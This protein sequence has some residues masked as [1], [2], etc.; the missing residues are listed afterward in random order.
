MPPSPDVTAG[1]GIMKLISGL[2]AV[3]VAASTLVAA[4]AGAATPSQLAKDWAASELTG[5]LVIGQYGSADVG[6]TID[7]GFAFDAMGRTAEAQLVGDAID[8]EL[9]P[10]ANSYGYVQGEEYSYPANEYL[11]TGRYANATAKAA[12]FTQRIDRDP[13]TQYDVNLVAQL[14]DLTDDTT[15]VIADE[16]NFDNY[17]NTIGQAFAAEALT[18]AGS[19]EAGP[20]T[21][22]LLAQQCPAGYFRFGL[23]A[24]PCA[25]DATDVAPDTTGLAVLSLL[26]SGNTSPDVTS[27]IAEATAWLESV[28]L[29][30]GSLAGDTAAPGSNSN[31][32]GLAGWALGEAGRQASAARA[33]AWTRSMQVADAGACSSQAPTGA[34]AYNPADLAAGRTSGITSNATVRDKWRRAT[35]QS[36]P[37]LQW[38]PAATVPVSISTP[39]TAT[40]KTSITA[41]VRG[42]AAGE[43]GCVS[44]GA[45]ARRVVGTGSDLTVSFTLPAG[46]AAHTF[47]VATLAGST[48]STTAATVVPAPTTPTPAEPVVGNLRASKVEKVKNNAFKIQ[49]TCGSTVACAGKIKVRSVGKVKLANGKSRKLVIAKSSYSVEPG[50]KVV[51]K[52]KLTKPARAALGSKRLRVVAEQTARGAE[53]STTKFWLRRK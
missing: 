7:A 52:L 37:V 42:L 27:A 22:A 49:V 30:D 19:E 46:A 14:E 2:A 31:S 20:A 24:A 40:E 21:T 48:T 45:D 25:V 38:A 9:L 13:T 33:A 11:G 10:S 34:I 51:V 36:A 12:A 53:S 4:P 15:G 32:T 8:A 28:Q 47:T 17:A 5:G 18:V 6:L 26:A 43:Q 29:T 50:K 39:A 3:A 44:F 41:T 16:T 23:S 1:E 35:F